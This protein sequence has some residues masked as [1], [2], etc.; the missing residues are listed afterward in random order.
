MT[1]PARAP[2]AGVTL[3]EMLV[4]LALF[5]LIGVAGYSVLETIVQTQARTEGRMERLAATDT[6]L[7]LL[8][9]D[10]QTGRVETLSYDGTALVLAGSGQGPPVAMRWLLGED[11]TLRRVIERPDPDRP[12]VAQ[13]ILDQV[14]G[15]DWRFLG[16]DGVWSAVWPPQEEG[17]WLRAVEAT[18]RLEHGGAPVEVTR[19]IV[20]PDG[21]GL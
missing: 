3:V 10:I 1:G 9:R 19:L 12:A 8:T 14:T 16:S 7:R 17:P 5:S 20:P 11:A 18:L 13:V 6:A 15:L 2:E 21:A 4:A